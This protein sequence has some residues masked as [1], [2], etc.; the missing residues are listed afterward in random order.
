LDWSIL[1]NDVEITIV[2]RSGTDIDARFPDGKLLIGECKGELSPSG[3]KSGLDLVALC[4]A[5][6]QLI[7]TADDDEKSPPNLVL[8][9]PECFDQHSISGG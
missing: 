1:K 5:I 7:I 8:V 3:V 4:S 6:G 2:S 9:L